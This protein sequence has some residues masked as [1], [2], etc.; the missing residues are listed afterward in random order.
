[1]DQD[2]HLYQ[3]ALNET[4]TVAM[5]DLTDSD[6]SSIGTDSTTTTYQ[7]DMESMGLMM[8]YFMFVGSHRVASRRGLLD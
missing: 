2:E 4:G 1:M 3:D 5:A 6:A 8:M 7:H